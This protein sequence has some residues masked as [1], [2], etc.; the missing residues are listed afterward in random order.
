MIVIPS[1]LQLQFFS[2]RGLWENRPAFLVILDISCWKLRRAVT[3]ILTI[4][5]R[6]MHYAVFQFRHIINRQ[7]WTATQSQVALVNMHIHL[8]GKS[9]FKAE[10]PAGMAFKQH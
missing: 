4:L 6:F 9:L 3:Q 7:F 5:S 1:M 10:M 8:K 2:E